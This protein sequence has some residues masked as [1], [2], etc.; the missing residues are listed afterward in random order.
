MQTKNQFL[1][2]CNIFQL[3]LQLLMVSGG[4][5]V[6]FLILPI[7]KNGCVLAAPTNNPDLAA[8][9]EILISKK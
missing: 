5:P 1:N 3:N 7:W 2:P 4:H 6:D 9:S 8:N